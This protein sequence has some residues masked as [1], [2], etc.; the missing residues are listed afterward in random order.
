MINMHGN[1][2][3]D[4]FNGILSYHRVTNGFLCTYFINILY[5]QK[6]QKVN[7]QQSTFHTESICHHC[8]QHEHTARCMPMCIVTYLIICE[9]LVKN[10][11]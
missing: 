10:S 5:D 3:Y 2:S 1:I 9:L 8:N 6:L 11:Q 4:I 7:T